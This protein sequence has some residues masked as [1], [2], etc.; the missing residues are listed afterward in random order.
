MN[1]LIFNPKIAHCL[2]GD[3]KAGTVGLVR[4]YYTKSGM[5]LWGKGRGFGVGVVL[6]YTF[7]VLLIPENTFSER[8]PQSFFNFI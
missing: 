2:Q 6:R 7:T 3:W 5:G 4:F 8:R 1:L